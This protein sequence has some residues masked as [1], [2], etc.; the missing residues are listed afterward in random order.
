MDLEY[1]DY[2]EIHKALLNVSAY[3]QHH[4]YMSTYYFI[5][6]GTGYIFNNDGAFKMAEFYDQ[7]IL[8]ILQDGGTSIKFRPLYRSIPQ[9]NS[10]TEENVFSYTYFDVYDGQIDPKIIVINLSEDYFLDQLNNVMEDGSHIELLDKSGTRIFSTATGTDLQ[11]Q[12][13]AEYLTE[14][15]SG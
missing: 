7:E 1:V 4:P 6:R 2:K 11:I 14:E 13:S 10:H 3:Y 15:E 9:K 12:D 5:N 8:Q